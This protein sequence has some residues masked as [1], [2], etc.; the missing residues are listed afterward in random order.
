MRSAA[1]LWD[2][3]RVAAAHRRTPVPPGQGCTSPPR[4]HR[5]LRG[6][7]EDGADHVIQSRV[8]F[9]VIIDFAQLMVVTD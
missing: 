3:S 8:P 6:L 7:W 1:L 4:H 2:G 9:D 5:V